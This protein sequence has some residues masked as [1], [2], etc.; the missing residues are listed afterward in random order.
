MPP[1]LWSPAASL[2]LCPLLPCSSTALTC[3]ACLCAQVAAGEQALGADG[4]SW[5]VMHGADGSEATQRSLAVVH[6][7]LQGSF[8]P[9][10]SDVSASA[11]Q[12]ALRPSASQL[13][14]LLTSCCF[15][16]TR[17][18]SPEYDTMDCCCGSLGEEDCERPA[19]TVAAAQRL[20]AALASPLSAAACCLGRRSTTWTCC[21]RS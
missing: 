14:F 1:L 4:H 13:C 15:D 16:G 9:I 20:P 17:V 7:V 18:S 3:A 8:D 21:P 12:L 6:E 19:R 5:L 2:R 11:A 10:I